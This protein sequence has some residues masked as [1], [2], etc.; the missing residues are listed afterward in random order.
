MDNERIK[1]KVWEEVLGASDIIKIPTELINEKEK[2]GD[3]WR[4]LFVQKFTQV[5]I[6]LK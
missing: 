1:I 5:K 3:N 4:K 2:V 6:N